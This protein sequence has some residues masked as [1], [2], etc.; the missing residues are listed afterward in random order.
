MKR[1]HS[2]ERGTSSKMTKFTVLTTKEDKV[3]IDL[4]L[5]KFIYATNSPFHIVE[6]AHFIQFLDILRPGYKPPTREK[7]SNDLLQ[8][9]FDAETEKI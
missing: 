5:A 8:E 7:I 6:N 3:R 2:A 4:A 1:S 9:I